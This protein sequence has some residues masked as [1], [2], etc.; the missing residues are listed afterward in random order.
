MRSLWRRISAREEG[1]TLLELVI[2]MGLLSLVLGS[3]LT[4]FDTMQRTAARQASRSQTTDALR[5]AMDRITK[6]IRQA[7]AVWETSDND[8]IEMDTLINGS[9]HRVAYDGSNGTEIV[10]V[11]DGNPVVLLE[12]LQT[13][14]I[15][16]YVPDLT[17]V[18]VVTVT[19]IAKPD[20]FSFDDVEITLTSEVRLRNR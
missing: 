4:V 5:I 9:Q 16:T 14:A 12:R 20:T 11:L 1:I 7:I 15:F 17:D 3:M 6:D 18:S 13:T 19:L 8:Y 2:G 10:R